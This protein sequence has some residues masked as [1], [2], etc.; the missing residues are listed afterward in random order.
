MDRIL[1]SYSYIPLHICKD[2]G[3]CQ[4]GLGIECQ[5]CREERPHEHVGHLLKVSV[6]RVGGDILFLVQG[7]AVSLR[8]LDCFLLACELLWGSLYFVCLAGLQ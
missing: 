6:V 5:G 7:P 4:M 1:T 8:S 2:V 3:S